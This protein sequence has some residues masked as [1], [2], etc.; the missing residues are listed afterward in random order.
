MNGSGGIR[1]NRHWRHDRGSRERN[2]RLPGL[3]E[4]GRAAAICSRRRRPTCLRL[5]DEQGGGGLGRSSGADSLWVSPNWWTDLLCGL[6]LDGCPHVTD[7][8]P[9]PLVR[10]EITMIVTAPMNEPQAFLPWKRVVLIAMALVA[11]SCPG[12]RP[13]GCWLADSAT[14]WRH[15]CSVSCFLLE[16]PWNDTVDHHRERNHP[17]GCQVF[18][19]ACDVRM[20]GCKLWEAPHH[21]QMAGEKRVF[22]AGIHGKDGSGSC[23][24]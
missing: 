21:E 1:L 11:L 13:A 12:V 24:G 6:L 23:Q 10:L 18:P 8:E 9:S 16:S 19:I 7:R 4:I 14:Q 3:F 20:R 5:G 22:W 15:F 17:V 2:R